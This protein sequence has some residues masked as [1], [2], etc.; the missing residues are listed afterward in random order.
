MTDV[1]RGRIPPDRAWP[2]GVRGLSSRTL[3]LASGLRVR[4]VEAGPASGSPVVLVHGW[5]CAAFSWRK[6]IAPLV[7]R[8]HRVVVPELKGHGFS[9]KPP[10]AA[11]YGTARMT[12]HLLEILDATGI[13]RTVLVGHSMG[14]AVAAAA[15]LAAPERVSHLV[16]VAPV[17]F[18]RVRA[19]ALGRMVSP[20]LM[21]GVA[22]HLVP[23][24]LVG[25][26][27]RWTF[28]RPVAIAVH[29]LEEYW[30]PTQF[31]AYVPALRHLLH[32]F[33]WV[34]HAPDRVRALAQPVHVM[35]GTRDRV[36]VPRQVMHLVSAL[37]HGTLELVEDGG[38]MLP[39]EAPDRIAAA[40]ETL[41]TG[42]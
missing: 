20:G 38:H 12:T 25:A 11:E 21:M 29:D 31:R 14:G 26:V 27:L 23:R 36:V 39:E 10:E 2:A 30:A 8:G 15:A 32:A 28:G 41:L 3:S 40:V 9:D 42:G 6:V 34:P 24:W 1:L 5:A 37:P 4:V 18:G 17:G 7:A 22:S 19:L 33:D 13:A 16:L 35:F